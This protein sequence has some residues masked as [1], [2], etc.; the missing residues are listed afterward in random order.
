MIKRTTISFETQ[1]LSVIRSAGEPVDLWC[2]DCG[3]VVPMFVPERIAALAHTA[4]R[5]IYRRVEAGELHF[6]END[7]G[8]LLICSQ[9]LR[10]EI[11]EPPKQLK[12]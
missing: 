2:K 5:E 10:H 11:T 9:S 3:L 12:S 4:P 7:S 6:V 8:E 1:R